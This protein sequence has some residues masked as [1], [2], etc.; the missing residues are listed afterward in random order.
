MSP[1]RDQQYFG[2]CSFAQGMQLEKSDLDLEVDFSGSAKLA[3]SGLVRKGLL[4]STICL[5]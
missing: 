2:K 1:P 4:V 3:T 5:A